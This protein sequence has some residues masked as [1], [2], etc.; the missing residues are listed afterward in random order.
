MVKSIKFN[1]VMCRKLYKRL[2]EQEMGK[3]PQERWKASPCTG[4][5][6]FGPFKVKRKA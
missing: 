5:D 1:C 4:G 2:T 3:I 6:I